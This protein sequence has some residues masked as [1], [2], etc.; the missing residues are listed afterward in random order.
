MGYGPSEKRWRAIRRRITAGGTRMTTTI[1]KLR[2]TVLGTT[3][4]GTTLPFDGICDP[5]AYI[6][7]W[8][9]HLLRVPEDSIGPERAPRMSVLGQEALMVT[10]IDADPFVSVTK[11]RLLA[12]NHDVAVNF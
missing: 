6:C 3:T 8:S 7:R 1:S 9:G 4:A 2:E 12:A 5:G 10:K 11:A